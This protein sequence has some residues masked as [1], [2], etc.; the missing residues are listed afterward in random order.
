MHALKQIF[1]NPC[2]QEA[3][4]A[5]EYFRQEQRPLL[6]VM[7]HTD[8]IKIDALVRTAWNQLPVEH[9]ERYRSMAE[10]HAKHL[11]G[12]RSGLCKIYLQA[13]LE[14]YLPAQQAKHDAEFS[15]WDESIDARLEALGML[16]R[17]NRP[18]LEQRNEQDWGGLVAFT[19]REVATTKRLAQRKEEEEIERREQEEGLV[20]EEEAAERAQIINANLREW[21]RCQVYGF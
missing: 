15:K 18:G 8:P 19:E 5:C 7:G 11:P 1:K 4:A 20:E 12:H 10:A 2:N 9:R 13:C 21:E 16:R 14:I 17:P 6:E 3:F